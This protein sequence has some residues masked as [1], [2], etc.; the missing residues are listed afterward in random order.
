MH[1]RMGRVEHR[2]PAK[3]EGQA[4]CRGSGRA[5]EGQRL[6]LADSLSNHI[7]H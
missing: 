6:G 5:V 2:S 4:K 7:A 3:V 1:F